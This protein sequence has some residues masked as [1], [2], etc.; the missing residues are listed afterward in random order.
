[1]AHIVLEDMEFFAYHGVMPHETELGNTFVITLDMEV[2]ITKAA[3]SDVLDDTINY[4]LIYN[5]IRKQMDIPSK[6]IEHIGQRIV[7]KLMNK[8]PRIKSLTLRLSK[9]NPPLGGKVDRVTIILEGHR[10]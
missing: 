10:D 4:Q 6:L 2:D 8:F 7:D 9:L 5:A 1:M 3:A